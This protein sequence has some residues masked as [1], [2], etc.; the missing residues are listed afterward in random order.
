MKPLTQK[1][2]LKQRF[3]EVGY[4][5]NFWAIDNYILRLSERIRELKSDGYDIVTLSGAE[6][7][8]P[9]QYRRNQYYFYS[10]KNP[11]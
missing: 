3:A 6:L 10:Y 9:K 7:N 1:E 8:K 11:Q 5:D 4:V 2:K